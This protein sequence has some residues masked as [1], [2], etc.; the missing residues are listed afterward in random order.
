LHFLD[1]EN[2]YTV[3]HLILQRSIK[4]NILVDFLILKER[5]YFATNKKESKAFVL[6]FQDAVITKYCAHNYKHKKKEC[7]IRVYQRMEVS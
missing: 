6:A 3:A 7:H 5:W 2:A 1:E 4:G